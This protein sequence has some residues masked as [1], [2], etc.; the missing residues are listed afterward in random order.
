MHE[1]FLSEN[2]MGRDNLVDLGI[3][4]KIILK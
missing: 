1:Q 2:H 4:E 3:A